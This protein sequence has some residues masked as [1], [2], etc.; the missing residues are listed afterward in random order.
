MNIS[1]EKGVI[2]IIYAEDQDKSKAFYQKVLESRPTLDVPGMTEFKLNEYAVLGI[3]PEEGIYRVL[4]GKIPHPNE[5][6][7]KPRCEIYIYVDDPDKYLDRLVEAGGTYISEGKI[8][9]WGD[10]VSYGSDLDGH[11]LAFAKIV[12]C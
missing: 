12:N 4:E 2:F 7:K 5:A 1:K 11:I 10:C 9:S 3:M 6:S 8:R